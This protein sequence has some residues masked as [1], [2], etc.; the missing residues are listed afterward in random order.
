MLVPAFSLTRPPLDGS[1]PAARS[2]ALSTRPGVTE[3]DG[4]RLLVRRQAGITLLPRAV[5]EHHATFL[6]G[7]RHVRRAAAG[8]AIAT[9]VCTSDGPAGVYSLTAMNCLVSVGPIKCRPRWYLVLGHQG[10][11]DLS[12]SEG[13]ILQASPTRTLAQ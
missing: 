10:N 11:F 6:A 12:T 2:W 5:L 8:G 1:L 13:R 3:G 4:P 9:V 7:G